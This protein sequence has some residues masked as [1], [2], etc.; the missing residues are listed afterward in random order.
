MP[1]PIEQMLDV[2][3]DIEEVAE[4]TGYDEEGIERF[5]LFE[6]YQPNATVFNH[7]KIP[8]G[9]EGVIMSLPFMLLMEYEDDH[10][11][12][13]Y[14]S[15]WNPVRLKKADHTNM[16][17]GVCAYDLDWDNHKSR[18]TK[19]DFAQFVSTV[20]T[21]DLGVPKPFCI[22]ETRGGIRMLY[23]LSPVIDN[24]EAFERHYIGLRQQ[25]EP[26]LKRLPGVQKYEIDHQ[27][28][29]WTRLFR[30]P[31]VKRD[32][33][34]EYDRYVRILH[35]KKLDIRQYHAE[36]KVYKQ[37]AIIPL[38]AG[39]Q[40][41]FM[42]QALQYVKTC[43]PAITGNNGHNTTF[44]VVCRLFKDFRCNYDWC[45]KMMTVYNDRCDP[46]WNESDL[47]HKIDDAAKLLNI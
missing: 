45:W 1:T 23:A 47:R 17:F 21:N 19:D 26:A 35:T 39:M 9:T 6:N 4:L 30:C 44:K 41:Q 28:W 33:V 18:P 15:L 2:S 27:T 40:K 38:P 37:R 12:T 3:K 8:G 13:Q 34:E 24:P 11:F 43:E 42:A 46:P 36:I 29:D 10:H 22:Y 14:T 25:L 7:A 20:A 32:G 5:S 31:R 16:S